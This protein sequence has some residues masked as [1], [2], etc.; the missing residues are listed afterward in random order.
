MDFQAS[1]GILEP[2]QYVHVQ[3]QG[4]APWGFTL[5]GGLEHGGPLIISKVSNR[6]GREHTLL[7]LLFIHLLTSY[8]TFVVV[9]YVC[10]TIVLCNIMLLGFALK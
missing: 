6:Q 2:L 1:D 8:P 4:G 3:L 9:Q 5:Q 10:I 7:M